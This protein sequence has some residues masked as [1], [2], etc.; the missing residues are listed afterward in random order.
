MVEARGVVVL[1][2]NGAK[3]IRKIGKLLFV[4]SA[5]NQ[6]VVVARPDLR[7]RVEKISDVSS[8]TEI[9]YAPN[10]DS[11]LHGIRFRIQE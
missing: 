2:R 1:T 6:C 9:P 8:D 5:G 4:L 11:D 3:V 7:E 10:I